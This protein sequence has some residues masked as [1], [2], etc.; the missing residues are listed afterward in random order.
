MNFAAS[1][2]RR[3]SIKDLTTSI[4]VYNSASDASGGGLSLLFRCWATKKMA[5]ST[6]NGRDSKPKN[7]GVKKFGGER[8]T[9]FHPRNYVGMGKG[10]TLFPMK[11]GLVQF[12][13][14]KLSG[15]EHIVPKDGH[16]LHPVY[17]E[18]AAAP[19]LKTAA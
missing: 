18:A 9:R 4:P 14:H 3:V 12:E 19:E 6:K 7:L 5:G 13:K 1:F 8:G 16:T 17:G 11:E 15:R 10:H 2:C